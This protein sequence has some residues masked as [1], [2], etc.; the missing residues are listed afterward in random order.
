MKKALEV[1]GILLM[2]AILAVGLLYFFKPE[3]LKKFSKYVGAP[4]SQEMKIEDFELLDH[5]GRWH[6]LH[7][8]P[9][10]AVV[11]ISTVNG[12]PAVKEAAPLLKTLRDKFAGQGVVFW[13]LDSNPGDDRA[14]I[15]REAEQLGLDLPVLEDRAQLVASAL[16][17]TQSC[18]VVC[19]S[20]TNWMT[21]YHGAI[22]KDLADPKQSASGPKNYL[23]NALTKFLANKAV[24]PNRTASKGTPFRMV[25]AK[26]PTLKPI[27]YSAEVA[28]ILQKSCVPCHSQGNIGPFAMSIYEKVK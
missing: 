2:S 24:S 16:G 20:S 22:N 4:N 14:S 6:D 19:I 27:S 25:I 11:L 5:K 9:G 15:V 3:A 12:C 17:I 23:E 10:R 13:L 1:G 26:D 7:R 18:D 28:P 21:F 8:Q